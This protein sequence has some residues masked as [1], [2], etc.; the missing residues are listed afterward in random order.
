MKKTLLILFLSISSMAHSQ[1]WISKGATWHYDWSGIGFGGFEK[2]IYTKDTLINNHLCNE[3]VSINFE[4]T[5]NEKN[6]LV[7]LG[8][9]TLKS[10]YTYV[11]GD[12]VFYLVND[13][14]DV[15][16]NFGAKP[17]DT[18]NLGVDTN[19]FKCSN[20][21]VKVD[22]IGNI[23]INEKSYRWIWLSTLDNSSV[24]LNGKIIERFGAMGDFLFP[25]DRNCDKNIIVD[26]NLYSFSCF[27]DDNFPLF[28][29]TGKDCEYLL[30]VGI[31]EIKETYK[32]YPIPTKNKL[33][34]SENINNELFIR[35]FTT[36]GKVVYSCRTR[37]NEID[38]S[39]IAN[40]VYFIRIDEK[41]KKSI[42]KKIVKI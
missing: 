42:V 21:V 35:I 20:S 22:S 6:E 40:G 15:L 10:Y 13:K 28:N 19:G 34:I 2:I 36:N 18:W 41:N 7:S 8:S 37:L 23:V 4:F 39:S 26:F 27:Q 3:L 33:Y 16:Y 30:K 12:T 25:T 32:L 1:V 24:G 9:D 14:F 29:V 31:P 38:L 5:Y 17:G 11:H